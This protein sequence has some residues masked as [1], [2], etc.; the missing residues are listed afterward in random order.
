M[1]K[2]REDIT[3]GDLVEKE[4]RNYKILVSEGMKG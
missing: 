4:T 3:K 2:D 1:T